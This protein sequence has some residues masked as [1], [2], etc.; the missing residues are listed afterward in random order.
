[1]Q[2]VIDKW[3]RR[4]DNPAAIEVILSVDADHKESIDEAKRIS[5]RHW[6]SHVKCLVQDNLPGNCVKGWNQAAENS[7]GLV[8]IAIADDF[9]PPDHWDTRLSTIRGGW[10][11]ADCVVQ[12]ADGYTSD[13]CTLG[14]VTRRRYEKFGYLFYPE[15]ESLFSDTE[16]TYRAKMD[17]CLI[18]ALHLTFEHRHPDAG[19][20]QRDEVDI[21]HASKARW[22]RG[23]MLFNYRL[24]RG[25]PIDAGPKANQYI[26]NKN[27]LADKY[28]VYTQAI[29]DDMCLFDVEKRLFDEGIRNFF[30]CVPDEYW[31]GE[32]TSED[33]I[34]QV[35]HVAEKLSA[36]G[37]NV[38]TR[39]F[40]VGDHRH[41][42]LNRI[43]VET[44]VRNESISWIRNEGFNH[45]L[46]VD[47]DELWRV[48]LLGRL[49]AI[50]SREFPTS[51]CCGMIPVVGLP[52]LPV[53]SA[54]DRVT[55]YVRGD[56]T[57]RECRSPYGIQRD[58]QE[59]SVVHFTATRPSMDEIVKKHKNSGHY[60]DPS[61]DFE[62]FLKNTL[63]NVKPGLQ[64]VHMYKHYQIWPEIR[65]WT[66][67]ELDDIPQPMRQ[68]VSSEV[69]NKAVPDNVP[70][71]TSVFYQPVEAEKTKEPSAAKDSKAKTTSG[72]PKATPKKKRRADL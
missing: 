4:S 9:E 47:G 57:F 22:N 46:I 43:G 32:A 35:I 29:K 44:C 62:G 65:K 16:L 19:K 23:E 71:I 64:N 30:F 11:Y 34:N 42:N 18:Q 60:D 25:F 39:I 41:F 68:F 6:L 66:Q 67:E 14:I 59:Y 27:P 38:R 48:G 1:M 58:M 12:V 7:K 40:K 53:N 61:Y 49:D 72:V 63:P 50:V 56:T 69:E 31:S 51:V 33:E 13:L 21:N 2:P 28:C 37:A 52:G 54:K 26:D 10:I 5:E 8:L 3:L 36:L 55:I 20:R 24:A 70:P 45:I 17:N 15:Y